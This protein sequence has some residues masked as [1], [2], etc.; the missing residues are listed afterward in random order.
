[1][2]IASIR[3]SRGRLREIMIPIS[4]ESGFLSVEVNSDKKNGIYRMKCWEWNVKNEIKKNVERNV[5]NQETFSRDIRML[6]LRMLT[7]L[8]EYAN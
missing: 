2:Q 1:M 8:Y 4:S 6:A 5:F 3:L 7:W